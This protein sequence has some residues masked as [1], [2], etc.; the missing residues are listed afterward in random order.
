ME[1][2]VLQAALAGLLHDVGKIIQR[3]KDDP[4]NPP[5][6]IRD[7]GQPVHA[8]WSLS[9]AQQLPPRY[10]G[11]ALAGGYHHHPE[12]SIAQDVFLSKVVSLA[13]KLSAGERADVSEEYQS[14]NPPQ[15]MLSVFD[16]IVADGYHQQSKHYLPLEPLSLAVVGKYIHP[17]KTEI[18]NTKNKYDELKDELESAVKKDISDPETYL[19][20]LLAEMQRISWCVP[21]AYYHSLP[22]V[23]LYDHS[24]MTAALAACLVKY[25]DKMIDDLLEAV[26]RSFENNPQPGDDI[27]LQQEIALLVGGD[28]SGVQDFIYTISSKGAA[29]MLR[30]RSFYLQLLSEAVLRYVLRE[31]ELPYTNVIYSGGGHFYL[32]APIKARAKLPEIQAEIGKIFLYQHSTDLYLVIGDAPIP[33]KGFKAGNLNEYWQNMHNNITLAKNRRYSELGDELFH[34][35][36]KVPEIGGNPD[37]S[38]S[39]CGD[40]RRGA[41]EWDELEA[42]SK[43]CPLCRSFAETVGK[44]L[45]DTKFLALKFSPPRN[46]TDDIAQT[47]LDI[48][49]K[50]GMEVQFIKDT[51]ETVNVQENQSIVLWALDDPLEDNWPK[52]P[53]PGVHWLRYTTNRVPVVRDQKEADKINKRL[54]EVK[55]SEKAHLN[56]PMTFTHL[57]VLTESGF[58]RLGVLRMD[59]DNLGDIFS[60]GLGSSFSLSRMATLSFQISLF[61]EGWL[62]KIV[63]MEEW[64][65]LVYTVYSGGDDLFLLA[66][67]DRVPYLARQIVE[68]FNNYTGQ[69][70]GLHISGGMAFI[71]GKYPI[72]Q[73]ADDAAEAEKIAKQ[74]NKNAFGFL[75]KR[76]QWESFDDL[77]KRKDALIELIQGINEG[78]TS[79]PKSIIQ[80]L[81]NLAKIEE[82]AGKDR[83]EKP[84]WGRW[85]W[86]GAYYLA[87]MEERYKNDLVLRGKIAAIRQQLGE[88]KNMETWGAASRWAQLQI[89][90][91]K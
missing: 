44:N 68:D 67:W 80:T 32:L 85:M 72:Y 63:E 12:R 41:Q 58:E 88:F 19:E 28:I 38:C 30:G 53:K 76:W 39:V 81:R 51:N 73:A 25:D 46:D 34:R 18:G 7:S 61:F 10:R 54:G 1:E 77:A 42:Q 26:K 79:G 91:K 84:L 9:F 47:A 45:P 22:D 74:E 86:M 49:S 23:S 66:P 89:R 16:R 65:N 62:K 27:I 31:L 48:L 8:A 64:N 69:H 11:A 71:D 87:R 37:A 21:A 20:H 52:L 60:K 36:F 43:I 13:D 82:D 55:E 29:K 70:R 6:D 40:D 59:V 24:R 56:Q 14:S 33:A 17:T 2:K 4:W 90:N 5:E 3:S 35:V 57:N 75:G 50:F 78:E 15:Q 83:L